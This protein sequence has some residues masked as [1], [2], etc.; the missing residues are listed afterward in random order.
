M[1]D[2]SKF[3]WG[4]NDDLSDKYLTYKS[5]ML[6]AMTSASR[7]LGLQHLDIRFMA[8]GI[9]HYIFT[10][11]NLHKSWRKEKPPSSLKVYTF[12]EDTKLC[13]VPT[14]E[15]YCNRTKV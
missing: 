4:K 5:A 13:V 7:V 1:I 10:F 9:N 11:G 12:E 6:L 14:M 15:E 8:K 2:F 3:E